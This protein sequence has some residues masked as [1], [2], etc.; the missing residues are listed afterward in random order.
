MTSPG[1]YKLAGFSLGALREESD[2]PLV[3]WGLL[4]VAILALWFWV[5]EPLQMWRDDLHNQVQRNAGKVARLMA[6]ER[7]ASQWIQARTDAAGAAASSRNLLF[8]YA[9]DTQ[10]QAAMQNLLRDLAQARGVTIESQKLM[11]AELMAPIGSRLV[12]EF[13]LRGNI[14]G[15]MQLMDDI[16][17]ADKLFVTERWAI[18]MDRNRSVFS[19]VRVAACRPGQTEVADS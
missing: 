13:T 12:I 19:R 1:K 14:A 11:P 8:D 2:S 5:V 9:S 17:G 7:N 10:A 3:R 4:L 18:Q 6:L 16:A 15:T